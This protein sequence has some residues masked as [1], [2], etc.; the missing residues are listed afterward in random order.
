ML[1]FHV[2][3]LACLFLPSPLISAT[4]RESIAERNRWSTLC[5]SSLREGR[6]RAGMEERR[7]AAVLFDAMTAIASRLGAPYP[8]I[9]ANRREQWEGN[10]PRPI[11][12]L[13]EALDAARKSQLELGLTLARHHHE[14]LAR[15]P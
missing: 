11:D 9:I 1:F 8:E 12:R 2:L 14:V 7:Q 3:I 15:E 6:C 5:D 4:E 10:R 13:R